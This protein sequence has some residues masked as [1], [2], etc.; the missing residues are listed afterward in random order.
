MAGL[1]TNTGYLGSIDDTNLFNYETSDGKKIVYGT[2]GNDVID[3]FPHPS[4]P[5]I[6]P[7]ITVDVYFD[8]QM[9][10]GAGDDQISSGNFDDELWGGD[11]NDTLTGAGGDNELYGGD[12]GDGEDV[13]VFR[14][15]CIEYNI[16]RNAD[17]SITISH[18][19]GSTSD[20]VDTLFDV[21][22]A[23]FAD[24]SEIDLTLDELYG[25]T[26]LG[27][28]R[29][30]VTGETSDTSISLE[31]ERLGDSSYPIDLFVD[32]TVIFGDAFFTDFSTTISA[33]SDPAIDISISLPGAFEDVGA[34][35][36]I[37]V[38]ASDPL[39]N[40]VTFSN[41]DIDILLIGD[42]VDDRGGQTW[43]DPHLL[44]FD[45]VGYDFQAAGEFVLVRATSGD[46]YEVQA[47]FVAISSAVSV[48]EAIATS[49]DGV[50]VAVEANLDS[51]AL[52]VD[53]V[54]TTLADGASISVGSSGTV[55]RAGD[56]LEIDHGNGDITS[57]TAFSTFLNVTP[58]PSLSRA[59]GE[60]EGLLGNANGTPIDDFRL[61]D[62]TVLS[63]PLSID[64]L[65]SDY[66][67][68]WLVEEANR[69]LP[70][71]PEAFA[72]PENV[73]SIDSLPQ[74]LREAAEAAVDA[75]GITNPI[76][77]D[78]A[79]LDFALTGNEEFIEASMLVDQNFDPIVDTVAVDTVVNPVVILSADTTT[80]DE[81]DPDARTVTFTVSRGSTDG[82]L[83]VNY[84]IAGVGG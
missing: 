81:D 61:S 31:L 49:V 6:G 80:L 84:T 29:D 65:Y 46:A 43:G 53:G 59:S 83:V 25:C 11:D 22:V 8:Y 77:R 39:G 27:F 48:T 7:E 76:L 23:R 56:T 21:E 40:F 3:Q 70:G 38:T 68:S 10:G 33:V 79:I 36:T 64:L 37:S 15:D 18:A 52:F 5:N 14:G 24:G 63:T 58:Q 42:G 69:L 26:S 82:D 55:T 4:G 51:G 41:P 66:A 13:A 19:R 1:G 12:G 72:A 71:D 2:N 74:S 35:V 50:S 75:M 60:L 32:G 62:G 57:V 54:E 47:R 16:V 45:N 67:N 73:I 78:A 20:G 34:L 44:T 28:I 17:D 9:V 30:F